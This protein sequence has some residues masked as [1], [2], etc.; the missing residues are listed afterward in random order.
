MKLVFLPILLISL[1][2]CSQ[3]IH[4]TVSIPY[5]ISMNAYSIHFSDLFSN[6]SNKAA[7]AQLDNSC[8]GIYSERRF[9]LAALN[10]LVAAIGLHTPHGN[11]GINTNYFGFG[12]YNE[13]QIGLAYSKKLGSK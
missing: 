13:T 1:F 2:A 3:A 6:S 5:Y 12:D 4:R 7:L 8:A 11:L 10:H 9:L